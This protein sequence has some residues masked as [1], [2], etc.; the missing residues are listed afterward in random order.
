MKT[1]IYAI[2]IIIQALFIGSC[3][4]E[5]KVKQAET[6]IA[7]IED[8]I[9]KN[10]YNLAKIKID[11]FHVNYRTMVDKR[12]VVAALEDTITLRESYRTIHYCDTILPKLTQQL[13]SMMKNFR[14]EKDER[15]Q[16][17][18][19]YVH[20]LQVTEQNVNRN[21]LKVK[22]DENGELKLFSY[23][24]GIKNSHNRLKVSSGEFFA[25]T[26]TLDSKNFSEHNF[27]DGNAYNELAIFGGESVENI[28]R[29]IFENQTSKIKVT[30]IGNK[31]FS[32]FL[33][34]QDIKAISDSYHFW[35][36]K[37]DI[38][39]LEKQRKSSNFK[40]N[41]ININNNKQKI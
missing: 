35:I 30:L 40:I 3:S 14:L 38:V 10:F 36:V 6:D 32:Y 5:K 24:T 25:E 20:K 39:K 22:I 13:D 15:F 2:L 19:D 11:S 17:T 37:K 33:S 16:E 41:R 27:I 18:G 26:D 1:Y 12:R 28:V 23:V 9:N 7:V 31:E 4:S 34:T 21:Y 29:F 8:L